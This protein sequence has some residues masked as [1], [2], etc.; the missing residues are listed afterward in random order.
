MNE[1]NSFEFIQNARDAYYK[2]L[3][4]NEGQRITITDDS[5]RFS[6]ETWAWP[7]SLGRCPLQQA[8]SRHKTPQTHPST[9]EETRFL[10]GMFE[11]GNDAERFIVEACCFYHHDCT[12]LPQYRLSFNEFGKYRATGKADMMVLDGEIAHIFEVKRPLS[13][14]A[15]SYHWILQT[16]F[17]GLTTVVQK[18][19][20]EVTMHI[21]IRNNYGISVWDFEVADKGYII[22]NAETGDLWDDPLNT[23]EAINIEA[24]LDR[25]TQ[26]ID[27]LDIVAAG[28]VAES[29]IPVPDPVNN[30]DGWQCIDTHKKTEPK[31]YKTKRN[32]DRYAEGL[33]VEMA[34]PLIHTDGAVETVTVCVKPGSTK[35]RCNWFCHSPHQGP[36]P[37]W[38]INLVEDGTDWKLGELFVDWSVL[39]VSPES[40]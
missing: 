34:L 28:T 8:Y 7:S 3:Y 13:A 12:I 40:D 4:E 17:Y 36:F 9:P 15:P 18:V 2:H 32:A 21:V 6:D 20:A 22:R 30:P 38:P 16:L 33:Y 11:Q 24:A 29:G 5:E 25:I 35:R 19:A 31:V 37:I 23:P 1:F 14:S 26:Q 39:D 27:W 10:Y